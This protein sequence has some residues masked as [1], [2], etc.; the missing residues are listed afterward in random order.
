MKYHIEKKYDSGNTD[1]SALRTHDLFRAFS[2]SFF[3]SG[4]ETHL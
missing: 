3:R 4:S 2:K 1:N